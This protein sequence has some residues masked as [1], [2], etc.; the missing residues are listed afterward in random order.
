MF[1]RAARCRRRRRHRGSRGQPSLDQRAVD[2]KVFARQKLAHLRQV[3]LGR[4]PAAFCGKCR[5]IRPKNWIIP[6]DSLY[7]H[8]LLAAERKFWRHQ[9]EGPQRPCTLRG[10][11][12]PARPGAK[13]WKT[14]AGKELGGDIAVEQTIPVLAKYSRVPQRIVRPRQLKVYPVKT[15]PARLRALREPCA[16]SSRQ[17]RLLAASRA[18]GRPSRGSQSNR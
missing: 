3:Q 9:P 7:Q 6:A 12:L 15:S 4:R 13:S 18:T 11:L 17:I 2:R 10:C 16:Q 1:W 5:R 8:L 14:H